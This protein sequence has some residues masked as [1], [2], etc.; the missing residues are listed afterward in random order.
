MYFRKQMQ[1]VLTPAMIKRC[2]T[3]KMGRVPLVSA[4]LTLFE[5]FAPLMGAHYVIDLKTGRLV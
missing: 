2:K 5:E 1:A 4:N 3:M